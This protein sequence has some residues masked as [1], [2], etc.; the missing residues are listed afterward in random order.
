M[1]NLYHLSSFTS[2]KKG[3]RIRR[4]HWG[5]N[6]K[7]SPMTF[8]QAAREMIYEAVRVEKYPHRPSRLECIFLCPNLES[9]KQFAQEKK[10]GVFYEV[11][12]MDS[13][14]K[15]FIANWRMM[16]GPGHTY[17]GA[18]ELAEEYWKGINV[19]SPQQELVIESDVRVIQRAEIR[20]QL[21][22]R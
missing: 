17:T 1:S 18:I 8:R 10:T 14:A 16:A 12:I 3:D 20:K 6:V 5:N 9:A 7:N 2:H 11:K 4:G 22:K 21:S 13:T 19:P 15:Q